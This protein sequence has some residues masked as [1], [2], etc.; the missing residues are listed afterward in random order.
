MSKETYALGLAIRM[1]VLGA[2]HVERSLAGAHDFSRPYQ[3]I[4]T[5][6]CLFVAPDSAHEPPA[7]LKSPAMIA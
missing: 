3:E 1:V 7:A 2:G 6:Y 4:M 5:E